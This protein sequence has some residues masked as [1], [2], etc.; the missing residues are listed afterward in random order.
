MDLSPTPAMLSGSFPPFP[1]REFAMKSRCMV[2]LLAVSILLI[3]AVTWA[4]AQQDEIKA[5]PK[6]FDAKRADIERGKVETIEYESK[7]VGS[8]RKVV[9]YTPPG[10]SKDN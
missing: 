7:T 10:Y 8:K 4:E 1:F 3:V 5:M 9:V 2:G 6:G